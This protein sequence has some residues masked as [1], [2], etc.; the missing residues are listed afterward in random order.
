MTT[1]DEKRKAPK[2]KVSST[3]TAKQT[4]L[5]NRYTFHIEWDPAS[6]K[7][8]ARCVMFPALRGRGATPEAALRQIKLALAKELSVIQKKGI[9]PPLAVHE[10][11]G[12]Y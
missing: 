9:V 12:G 2:A 8:L 10:Q 7:H 4:D 1:N 3:R 5:I 6:N 11:T